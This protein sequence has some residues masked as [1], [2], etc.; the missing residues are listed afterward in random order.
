MKSEFGLSSK[1]NFIF[2]PNIRSSLQATPLHFAVIFKEMNNV[3]LLIKMEADLNAQDRE[4][5]TP[6]HVA[7]I[8]LC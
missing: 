4:G 2:D 3:E 5:R 7:I 1:Y 6:L 8:R